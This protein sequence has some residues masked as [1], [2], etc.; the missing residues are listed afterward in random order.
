MSCKTYHQ[1]FQPRFLALWALEEVTCDVLLCDV[2]FYHNTLDE[3]AVLAESEVVCVCAVRLEVNLDKL[4]RS[5]L[6]YSKGRR[7]HKVFC[8]GGLQQRIGS[9]PVQH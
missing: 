9:F 5:W 3:E 6:Y 4:C 7:H 2:I 1:D 8:V